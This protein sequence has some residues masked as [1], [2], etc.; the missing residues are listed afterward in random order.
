MKN[1]ILNSTLLATLVASIGAA[2]AA[3]ITINTADNA[4]FSAGKTNLVYALTNIND[5]DTIAFNIPGA[6]PHYLQTPANGYPVLIKDRVTVDGYTQPGASANSNPITTSNNAV[7]KIVLDSRNNNY[8]DMEYT[9]FTL[10]N[11]SPPIDNTSMVTERGGYGAPERAV[12]GVYRATNVTVRGLAF[13]GTFDP[14]AYGIAV[15]HDYGLDTSVKDRLAYD[16]GSSRNCHINGC[17]FG[18]D[19]TNQTVAGIAPFQDAIAFFRHRDVSGGPRPELPNES[20]LIGVKAGSSNPRAEFNVFAYNFYCIAGEAVRTRLSGN[21]AGVFPDG[22]TPTG[23][24]VQFGAGFEI[25]RYNDTEPIIIGTD[26]DGVNDADEGNLFGPLED[27]GAVLGF[28]STGDKLYLVSGN[29]FGVAVDGSRWTNS[30]VV[31][32]AIANTTKVQF[33]SDCNGV[34]DAWEGNVIYNNSPFDVVF[35]TPT[36]TV[37]PNLLVSSPGARVSFRGNTT[38]NNSLVPFSFADGVGGR[39]ANYL[40]YM[41]RFLNTNNGPQFVNF[42]GTTNPIPVLAATTTVKKLIGTCPLGVAEYTNIIIDVYHADLEGWTNGQAFQ[43]SELADGASGFYGFAQGRQYLGSYVD[44]GPKDLNPVAGAFEFDISSANADPTQPLTVTANYSADPPGTAR[45]RVHTSDFATPV[46]PVPWLPGDLASV[47]GT[48]VVPDTLLWYDALNGRYTNGNYN[49]TVG[50]A[51]PNLANWEPNIDVLGDSTFLIEA[52]TFADDG[53]QAN[54]RYAVTLQ[55]AAGG[56]PK[57]G[58]AFFADNGTP[59]RGAVNLSRQNGNPGRVAGDKRYGAVNFI[60]GGEVSLDGF[61][62]FQSDTRWTSNTIYNAANRYTGVQTFSLNPLTLAQTSLTKAFDAITGRTPG[63]P[64][65][66]GEIARFGGHLTVLD[67]GNMVVVAD[68]RSGM[69]CPVRTATIVVIQPNGSIVKETFAADCAVTEQIW[70]NVAAFRGG[71]CVRFRGPDTQRWLYFYDNDGNFQGKVTQWDGVNGL[72]TD[73]GR[74]DGTRIG[75][76]I[77]SP[78]VYLAGKEPESGSLGQVKVAVFDSRTRSFVTKALVSET[79]PGLHNVDRVNVAADAL[80]R[81]CVVYEV[82]PDTATYLTRQVAVRVFA[83]DGINITPVTSSFYPF[84][85]NDTNG[86]GG[87]VTERMSVAMTPRQI[88]IAG[89][90][91]VNSTN[92]PANGPD[93]NPETTIYT[94]IAHPAPVAAPQPLMTVTRS[95]GNLIISWNADAGLFT[96]QSRAAL[97]AGSWADVNPQPATVKVGDQHQMTI[98][99]GSANAFLQLLRRW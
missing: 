91:V 11:S 7:I 35:P 34:S 83:F 28:Y 23:V 67:N 22:V 55:P 13:L 65:V 66:T 58:D 59:Y 90:G 74:G 33:G 51:Q 78:Y 18:I 64:V 97:T 99:V 76:D 26:G 40:N 73:T 16:A 2:N 88:C 39:L 32:D 63:T 47:G 52:N 87:I 9:L 68:D 17:W 44:N 89:K 42:S 43:L 29:R 62:P 3:T 15:A 72:N 85:N 96:L 8:R 80:N 38:V 48:R 69:I 31:F 86:S 54:Q 77:R 60:A 36:T 10:A 75:A 92:S 79:T 27:G 98:P 82:R 4:D 57:I 25:G 61:A 56:A 95:G 20:L 70:A 93:T 14:G 49:T 1:R 37:P 19:P 41:G 6:G 94:V 5:G 50:A 12:L 53:L 45:G 84:I 24:P 71:F 46:T 81:V 30:Q 21:F